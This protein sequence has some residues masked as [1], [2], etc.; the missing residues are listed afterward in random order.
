[1]VIKFFKNR[2]TSKKSIHNSLKMGI[3]ENEIYFF[4]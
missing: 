2:Y 4:T 3:Q 1:M